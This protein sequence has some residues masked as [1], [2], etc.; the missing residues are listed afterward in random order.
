MEL[1]E[2]TDMMIDLGRVLGTRLS[3]RAKSVMVDFI[4]EETPIP[5]PA[6]L[7][8]AR[9][10]A[11]NP[12]EPRGERQ[13]NVVLYGS[14][15][16]LLRPARPTDRGSCE[17]I[18]VRQPDELLPLCTRDVRW[19]IPL[20]EG[21]ACLRSMAPP[22]DNSDGPASYVHTKADATI[23]AKADEIKLGSDNA[24]EAVAIASKVE[25][26]LDA[27]ARALDALAGA[28]PGSS[29]G[30]AALQAALKAQ[31]PGTTPT[32]TP[33]AA[34]DVAAAKVKVE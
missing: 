1:K 28:V 5:P 6:S 3:E 25:E 31:W 21:D 7:R 23:T 32:G 19:Q 18:F 34:A 8:E 20:E 30:G 26:R 10:R 27:I 12:P 15:A 33:T 22:P 9:E 24:S 29:D 2:Y 17:V 13:N 4:G 14:A 11:A 16:V